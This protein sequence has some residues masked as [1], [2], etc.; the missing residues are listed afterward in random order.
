MKTA[1]LRL[2]AFGLVGALAATSCVIKTGDDDGDGGSSTTGGRN[3]TGGTSST[4]GKS[5]GGTVSSTGG[6][7]TGGSKAT[8]GAAGT[9]G[10]SSTGGSGTGGMA[11]VIGCDNDKAKHTAAESCEFGDD[12][13]N[14]PDGACLKCLVKVPDC[15]TAIKDC[16]GTN[17]FNQCGYGGPEPGQTEYLCYRD[18]LLAKAEAAG[19]AYDPD[20]D[21]DACADSCV[22]PACKPPPF[23]STTSVLVGCMHDNCEEECFT[24]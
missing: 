2:S 3:S 22:T 11:I 20:V 6:M 1:W 19:G 10:G 23:G 18:C 15:C 13:L 14:G 4:G 12:S 16:Y 21:T 5:T 17:T 24:P 9:T 8:G 7:G